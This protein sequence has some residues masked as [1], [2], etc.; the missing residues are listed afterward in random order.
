MFQA[1]LWW[2]SEKE[3]D[4]GVTINW[5]AF[6]KDLGIEEMDEDAKSQEMQVAN[7]NV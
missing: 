7:C 3:P 2:A 4:Y 6:I 5:C 1:I